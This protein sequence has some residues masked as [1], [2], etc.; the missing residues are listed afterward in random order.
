MCDVCVHARL[1]EAK[2]YVDAL[3]ALQASCGAVVVA[4]SITHAQAHVSG[5]G[6]QN[7]AQPHILTSIF[8][9]TLPNGDGGMARTTSSGFGVATWIVVPFGTSG[10]AGLSTCRLY[11]RKW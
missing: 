5:Y 11:K 8:D 4:H 9:S 6:T 1:F 7:V 2:I 3:C 10:V